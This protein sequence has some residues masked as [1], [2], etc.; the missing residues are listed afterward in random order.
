[1]FVL[2]EQ[3]IDR[4]YNASLYNKQDCLQRLNEKRTQITELFV[5]GKISKSNYDSKCSSK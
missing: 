2:Y 3:K 4:A 1:L 5:K